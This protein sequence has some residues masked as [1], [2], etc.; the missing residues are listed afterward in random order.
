MRYTLLLFV[1]LISATALH[2]QD[3]MINGKI[4]DDNGNA[5]PFATVYIKNTTKGASANSDGEYTL[6]LKKG[7]YDIQYKAVGYKQ[8]SR[9]VNLTANQ[10]LNVVLKTEEYQLNE[11]TVHSG[12][13]DPAYAIIRKAIKK[14][15]SYLNQVDAFT[16]EVY[17]KGLQ[18][19]LAA[20]KK[21]LGFDVQKATRE[22]GLDSNR[23]GIIY[24]SESQSKFSFMQPD[25][26]HE[27]LVS[28]KVSGSNKAFSYNRASDMKVDFYENLQYWDGLSN[29]PLISPIADNALFYYKYTWMGIS[30]ENGETINKIRVTPR[31][32]HDPCFSGYIYILDDSWRLQSVG[33]YIT[34]KANIN[35]VDTLK[36]DQQFF[37]VSKDVW[38]PASVKFEF[39]G[40][41]FGFKF[42]GYFISLYKNYDLNPQLNK[43]DFNEVLKITKGVNKKD[44]TYWE[45]ERPIPLTAEEKTDYQKKAV[46]AAKRESKPYLDSLDSVN[47]KVSIGKLLLGGYNHRN[48]YDHEYYNFNSVLGS[49]LYNT[50]EGFAIDY[51]A[52]FTKQIDSA[53]N[54][55]LSVYGKARYGFSNHLFNLNGGITVP[56]G[57]VNLNFTG[58]SDVLDMNNRNSITD[59]NNTIH[60]LFARENFEKLYQKKYAAAS[61]ST[62]ISGG[63]LASASVEWANRKW[64]PNTSY[65]SIFHPANREYSSNNPLLPAQDVPLFPENQSFKIGF[66]TTYNFSNKY[67]TYPAGRRYLPSKYPTIG[68]S[69]TKAVKN[70]LGADADYS[71]IS[72]DVTKSDIPLGMYGRTSFYIAAG[73]FFDVKNIYFTDFR[74]FSGN[75]ALFYKPGESKFL[76][77]DYYN[78]ST[79]NKYLE[80]H[81]EHNFS[82]FIFNKIPLL[83]SLK[84]QE[85]VDVN[86]LTT[87]TLKNYTELGFGILTPAGIRIM[88]GTTLSGNS[89]VN[90]AIRIGIGF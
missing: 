10:Q 85:L 20:P 15:K 50:V 35:F 61:A 59:F 62:R 40:G 23:T 47:N 64:L 9:K 52:S 1:L 83:R 71:L 90:S 4:T 41:I 33:L 48:R 39:T 14:R 70:V 30:I 75:Q 25:N 27:E 58:G 16:C 51:G 68:L 86:Y 36:V 69:F 34:K 78:F 44:S 13:E 77:L 72:A 11:V 12:G 87:P 67:E 18:K 31:R 76:L 63:W 54:R 17:I 60:S 3:A 8:E 49:L 57:P 38:M 88:Y 53:N 26:V 82:G 80:G 37:P 7:T 81:L 79:G 73:K 43:K 6:T 45:Q 42:G 28:S 65:F 84:L 29:R 89:S 74:H 66:R 5:V 22:A 55:Y 24:L 19:L 46:L 56:A 2:A 21:F 32:E